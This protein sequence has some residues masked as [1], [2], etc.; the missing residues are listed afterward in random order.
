MK[1]NKLYLNKDWLNSISLVVRVSFYLKYRM[2]ERFLSCLQGNRKEVKISSCVGHFL[3]SFNFK[4]TY[5]PLWHL[6]STVSYC[7]GAAGLRWTSEPV[8]TWNAS[9]LCCRN[10]LEG[11]FHLCRPTAAPSGEEEWTISI[12]ET[13]L[14]IIC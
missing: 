8:V 13:H 5:M 6:L 14:Y 7:M 12:T 3:N 1:N 9:Q 4:I 10:S 2:H 11:P